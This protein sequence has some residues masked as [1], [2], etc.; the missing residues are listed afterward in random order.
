MLGHPVNF[1][2]FPGQSAMYRFLSG[3]AICGE[4]GDHEGAKILHSRGGSSDLMELLPSSISVF[5][6]F[7]LVREMD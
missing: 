1:L 6:F 7:L 3:Y 4:F 5:I 2:P